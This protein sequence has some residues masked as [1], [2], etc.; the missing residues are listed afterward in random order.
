MND[1]TDSDSV[2]GQ[3][4]SGMP[5]DLRFADFLKDVVACFDPQLRHTYVNSA[6]ELFTG[7]PVSHFIGRTNREL[8]MPIA[9][10]DRW[11]DVL[12]EVFTSGR[13][14]EIHFTFDSPQGPRFF[15]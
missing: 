9:L 3:Q 8:G 11:D 5:R 6:V 10:V 12:R 15:H 13:P 14:S 2:K 4:W 1:V 7:L